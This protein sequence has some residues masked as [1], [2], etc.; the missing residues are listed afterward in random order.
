[1]KNNYWIPLP[2]DMKGYAHLEGCYNIPL[3]LN[4]G[5]PRFNEGPR[6]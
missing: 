2:Y 6:D 5:E 3:V 4:T 1:M